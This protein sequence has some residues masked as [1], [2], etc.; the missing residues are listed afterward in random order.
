MNDITFPLK[1]S[2]KVRPG[3]LVALHGQKFVRCGELNRAFGVVQSGAT[4]RVLTDRGWVLVDIPK[5][6][7]T[8]G[9]ATVLTS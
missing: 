1:F 6:I 9:P 7:V 3:M 8:Y 4:Q 5:G 2:K